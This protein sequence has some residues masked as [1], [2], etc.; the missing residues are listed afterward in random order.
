MAPDRHDQNRRIVASW[1]GAEIE[2]CCDGR[3]WTHW[4]SA[5]GC[6]VGVGVVLPLPSLP[7]SLPLSIDRKAPGGPAAAAL[8]GKRVEPTLAWPGDRSPGCLEGITVTMPEERLG[9]RTQSQPSRGAGVASRGSGITPG[10][11]P[12]GE[13]LQAWVCDYPGLPQHRNGHRCDSCRNGQTECFPGTTGEIDSS[14]VTIDILD[15]ISDVADAGTESEIRAI[16]RIFRSR[17]ALG[18]V[19]FAR[20]LRGPP[21]VFDEQRAPIMNR[22]DGA[23]PGRVA[24]DLNPTK[25]VAFGAGCLRVRRYH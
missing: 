16:A 19:V 20:G 10:V 8:E 3:S 2:R 6:G 21:V 25:T 13:P 11:L 1:S 15:V 24:D 4:S 9:A 23:L 22:R 17:N 14:C 12:P 7:G 18:H 5:A